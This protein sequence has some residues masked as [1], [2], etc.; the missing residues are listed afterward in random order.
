MDRLDADFRY[1]M[2]VFDVGGTLLG[3]HEA[4]PF[5]E[6]LEQAG[7]PASEEEVRR[8]HDRLI[9][10]IVDQR[11]AAQGQGA[12]SAELD[13]WWR[14]NFAKTW[15]DRPDLAEKMFAWLMAGRFDRLFPDVVP[16]LTALRDAGMP[17][18]VLSNWGTHL[19]DVLRR[20]SL[21]GCFEFITVSAEVGLAKPDRR[22]FDLVVAQ[23]NRPRQRLLYVGDHVGDDIEGA[24][25]AGLDAVLIDRRD[26][27]ANALCPRIRSL[28]ELVN[29]VRP[30]TRPAQGILL[31]MD[32]VVLASPPLH[33]LTWQQTLAPLGVELQAEDLHRLEGMPTERIAQRLTEQLLGQACSEEEARDL[34]A[35]K[36]AL[37]R[38]RFNSTFVPGVVPL[39]HDL[40]GRGYRLGLVTGSARRVVEESLAPSGV[41]ALFDVLVTGDDV[42]Q[43]K[44]DPEPYRMAA[45][46]LGLPPEACLVIENAPLGIR[47]AR[48]A[49]MACVA[50]E[51]TL[52]AAQL[53][54]AGAARVFAE[55]G[56]LRTWLL[57]G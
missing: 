25:G 15:P 19:H 13:A 12:K 10:V 24:R 45:A 5:R 22:I 57:Y 43:G 34:A 55:A 32:G 47:S 48:A 9:S 37:F 8:F 26:Q 54:E 4:A 42:S 56:A 14:G 28:L 17:M 7:L 11:D 27:Q 21:A 35:T 51:T 39:L 44:P 1:D 23:A 18:A 49:G 53:S 20:F 41:V 33:L 30:P 31:D 38:E 2:V 50:L 36:R 46:R 40:R 16:A 6:F 3:F 29:Y 52:P